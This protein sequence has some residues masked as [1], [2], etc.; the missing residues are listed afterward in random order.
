MVFRRVPQTLFTLPLPS[1]ALAV[2]VPLFLSIFFALIHFD[3]ISIGRVHFKNQFSRALFD[4]FVYNFHSGICCAKHLICSSQVFSVTLFTGLVLEK[5][6]I[7]MVHL[8]RGFYCRRYIVCV[9]EIQLGTLILC[10]LSAYMRKKSFQKHFNKQHSR[11]GA[12]FLTTENK[13]HLKMFLTT[14]KN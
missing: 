9:L 2:I 1:L 8:L 3:Y 13:V 14:I 11:S 7:E 4:G 10:M 6:K 12:P 5:K